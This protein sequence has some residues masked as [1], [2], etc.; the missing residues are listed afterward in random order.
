[1]IRLYTIKI[2]ALSKDPF[3]DGVP[4]N[5]W[6]FIE[7]NIAIVCSSVPGMISSSETIAQTSLL[8]QFLLQ[9]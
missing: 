1:M 8:I 4:I 5:I 6:S 3:Y 9:P 7:V 2:F